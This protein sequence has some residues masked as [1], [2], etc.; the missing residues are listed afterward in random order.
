MRVLDVLQCCDAN[1]AGG[2]NVMNA[3]ASVDPGQEKPETAI[4]SQKQVIL[5]ALISGSAG[6]LPEQSL[7]PA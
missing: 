6:R 1:V 5:A 3:L 7:P 4:V 2:D